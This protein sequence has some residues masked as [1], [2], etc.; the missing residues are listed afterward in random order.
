M[1]DV[2]IVK[3]GGA[4]RAA[5]GHFLIGVAHFFSGLFN[6]AVFLMMAVGHDAEA[7]ISFFHIA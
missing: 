5:D 2:D 4:G 7:G 1:V 6:G 3:D